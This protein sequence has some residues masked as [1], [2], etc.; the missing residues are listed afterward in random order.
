MGGAAWFSSGGGTGRL[1]G[2][3]NLEPPT[4]RASARSG[5]DAIRDP[6]L[7]AAGGR[8]GAMARLV[9]GV[10]AVLRAEGV[11]VRDA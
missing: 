10:G 9:R 1:F 7:G 3:V 2:D 5:E 8:E 11:R 4:W 6:V